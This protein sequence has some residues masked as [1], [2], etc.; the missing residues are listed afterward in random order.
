MVRT[1]RVKTCKTR[2]SRVTVK[3]YCYRLGS[4]SLVLGGVYRSASAAL[5]IRVTKVGVEIAAIVAVLTAIATLTA[6][7]R[8]VTECIQPIVWLGSKRRL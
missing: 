1:N 3:A 8:S 7:T 2:S 4:A 6:E 5:L